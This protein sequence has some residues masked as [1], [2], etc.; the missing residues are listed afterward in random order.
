M[1]QDLLHEVVRQ[2][3]TEDR[4]KCSKC[5]G[6]VVVAKDVATPLSELPWMSSTINLAKE[7]MEHSRKVHDEKTRGVVNDEPKAPTKRKRQPFIHQCFGHDQKAVEG[8][9]GCDKKLRQALAHEMAERNASTEFAGAVKPV[10]HD[11]VQ[12]D[13]DVVELSEE[14]NLEPDSHKTDGENEDLFD[15][16]Q[17]EKMDPA[18]RKRG[19]GVY[20]RLGSIITVIPFSLQERGEKIM[21]TAV[22]NDDRPESFL[23]AHGPR[24]IDHDEKGIPY[25]QKGAASSS[26]LLRPSGP[27]LWPLR[28]PFP[29]HILVSMASNGLWLSLTGVGRFPRLTSFPSRGPC[30][31]IP[32]L[33]MRLRGSRIRCLDTAGKVLPSGKV[34]W[35]TRTLSLRQ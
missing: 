25:L 35:L 32:P 12:V 10:P 22:S 21:E 24:R 6:L 14:E 5:K 27:F 13:D 19:K 29:M 11:K 2:G 3:K 34:V 18:V 8:F 16:S 4:L 9:T 20:K 26:L 33:G 30:S 17:F 1:P 31:S 28:R 15:Q 23:A 7:V